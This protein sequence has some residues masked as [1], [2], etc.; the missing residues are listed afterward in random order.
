MKPKQNKAYSYQGAQVKP[1]CQAVPEV[2]LELVRKIEKPGVD[3]QIKLGSLLFVKGQ[4]TVHRTDDRP[5]HQ[6]RCEVG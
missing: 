6:P 3:G 2:T 5:T 1:S 4:T